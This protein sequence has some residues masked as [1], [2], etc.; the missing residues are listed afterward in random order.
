RIGNLTKPL[1][2]PLLIV[3]LASAALAGGLY[4]AAHVFIKLFARKP[5]LHTGA[6]I[7]FLASSAADIL[8]TAV[9]NAHSRASFPSP[10]FLPS[11]LPPPPPQLTMYVVPSPT[12]KQALPQ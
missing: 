3:L 11:S 10:S 4:T 12:A 7:W 5:E 2:S 6:L 9:L 8:I 1:W